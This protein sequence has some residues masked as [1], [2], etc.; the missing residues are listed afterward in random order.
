MNGRDLFRFAA[1]VLVLWGLAGCVTENAG[2]RPLDPTPVAADPGKI[3]ENIQK[4]GEDLAPPALGE[5]LNQLILAGSEAEP[6]LLEALED[7]NPRRRSNA[8]FV[9]GQVGSRGV[10]EKIAPLLNDPVPEVT[11][12]AAAVLV[13]RAHK[14]GIP[15]LIR[16]LRHDDPNIQRKAALILRAATRQ[17]FGFHVTDPRDKREYCV[18][19]W[20]EWWAKNGADF[21]FPTG[22]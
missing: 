15:V 19:R 20:E 12:E 22:W 14:Q 16:A 8:A 3:R 9:L 2:V 5:V 7:E 17:Y 1:L 21:Q 10:V 4:L 13:E 11:F 18:G 6:F